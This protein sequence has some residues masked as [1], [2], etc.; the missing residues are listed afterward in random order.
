[1][2]TKGRFVRG[3]KGRKSIREM[4]DDLERRWYLVMTAALLEV[5]QFNCE[6]QM[7]GFFYET[8]QLITRYYNNGLL[9]N[10][11]TD[12]KSTRIQ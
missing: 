7:H 1:M 3:A 2:T 11:A 9:P 12:D 6:W 8:E 5:G 10:G 4:F